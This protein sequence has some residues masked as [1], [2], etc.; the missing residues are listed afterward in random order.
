MPILTGSD[1]A[2]E[3]HCRSRS[4][5]Q[6]VDLTGFDLQ[7]CIKAQRGDPSPLLVLGR[8][9][10]LT[11]SDAPGGVVTLALSAAQTTLLGPG[12]RVWGLYRTDGG[13]R[14]ALAT[15]KMRVTQ[16]V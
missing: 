7:M 8:D 16:G 5:R 11:I 3:I 1:Y 14:L 10:G 12:D 4:T 9:N 2:R 6:P 15:G 13:K